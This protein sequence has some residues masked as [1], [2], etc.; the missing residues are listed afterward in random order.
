M[1]SVAPPPL[2]RLDKTGHYLSSTGDADRPCQMQIRTRGRKR[3]PPRASRSSS[4]TGETTRIKGSSSRFPSRKLDRRQKITHVARSSPS[5]SWVVY[6]MTTAEAHEFFRER[7]D[8]LR[9]GR[10][11]SEKSFPLV[12]LLRASRQVLV[13]FLDEM[14]KTNK[15]DVHVMSVSCCLGGQGRSPKL[16]SMGK[17]SSKH[18][19]TEEI[20]FQ[21]ARRISHVATTGL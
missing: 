3:A 19:V 6:I 12:V 21:F 8:C 2:R 17:S 14:K 9:H 5:R 7:C 1:S 16:D 20:N 11:T 4:S 15:K 10:N 18:T 13:V